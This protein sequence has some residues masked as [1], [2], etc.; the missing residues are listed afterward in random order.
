[1]YVNNIWCTNTVTLDHHCS[2]DLEY[3]TIKCRPIYLPQEFTV[4]L[5]TAVY[6]PPD[7]NAALGLLNGSISG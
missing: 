2:L 6:I 7:A 4:L 3:V 1:M 5:I